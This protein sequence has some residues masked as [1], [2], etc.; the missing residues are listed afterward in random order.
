MY[1][2]ILNTHSVTETIHGL[3]KIVSWMYESKSFYAKTSVNY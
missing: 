3:N 1:T 2:D